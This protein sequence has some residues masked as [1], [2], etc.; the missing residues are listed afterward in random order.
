MSLSS[1]HDL[2][3]VM[4]QFQ[5][6]G[7]SQLDEVQ[8]ELP[9]F[10]DAHAFSDW[11]VERGYLTT[12]QQNQL[13]LRRGR[14]LVLGPYRLLEPLGEGGMGQVF[15][16]HHQRLNRVVAL[17]LIRR[18]LLSHQ[19]DAVR[20]FQRE[21]RAVA[22]L[23]HPNVVILYDA[24][25]VDGAH[26]LAME[27][28]DGI[29][30]AQMVYQQGPLP[31]A[32]ACDYVRQ[33]ALG[34]QHAY[35]KGM[36]HRDIKPGNLLVTRPSAGGRGGRAS[37]PQR[38]ASAAADDPTASGAIP[39]SPGGVVKIL[40]M[41][42]VRLTEQL[43][44]QSQ[45]SFLTQHGS[46][47]GTPDFIAP[48]QARDASSVDIRAD[49][50]SLGCT[51]Y[52]L[53]TGRQPF[54]TGSPV[55]KLLKHQ[56]E[57]PMPVE[58][59]RP[60]TP[61]E[62]VIILQRMMAKDRDNRYQTPAEVAE[63]LA[64]L[65]A[66]AAFAPSSETATSSGPSTPVSP[67]YPARS[68]GVTQAFSPESLVLAAR[69]VA[70]MQG[71][72]GYV[73]A[74]A[75][76]SD[77]GLLASGGVDSTVRLW[78]VS[79]AQAQE[80]AVLAANTGEVSA[81]AF[82]PSG[83]FLVT[84]AGSIDG[85]LWRWDLS[86]SGGW[87]R[88]KF[89]GDSYRTDALAFSADG[90]LLAAASGKAVRLW[91]ISGKDVK[92]P[93][94]LQG[95]AGIVRDVAFAPDNRRFA[96][97]GEDGTVRIWEVGRFW[98]SQKTMFTGHTD[99]VTSVVFSPDGR[100]LASA[101]L[102]RSIRLWDGSGATDRPLDVFTG[103]TNPIRLARFTPNGRLLITVADGGQV[104]LWDVL[105]RAKVREW[106]LDQPLLYSVAISPSGRHLAVGTGVGRVVLLDL[107]I[108]IAALPGTSLVR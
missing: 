28:V 88:R 19:P 32:Q 2:F 102:D 42:L 54:P 31:I 97:G 27:Y 34:L 41:G 37:G 24:D 21:A 84:G 91:G 98:T 82:A 72:K 10:A 61:S 81:V 39:R 62:V 33:A 6:L 58:K 45:V 83:S 8:R 48:E 22:Q 78:D 73:M 92:R 79:S 96:S 90:T 20:R 75:F 52:F 87:E 94:V 3:E 13:L 26:F 101:S 35:E 100:L 60:Q 53:L 76:S 25:E 49:I 93:S 99:G 14:E 89:P 66:P 80:L 105:G 40:D 23:L 64:G 74:L 15:K 11:L 95:H 63:A 44:D 30:L 18:E 17:K 59:I 56:T 106:Q 43:G 68:V 104:F 65:H 85:N 103:H 71:H 5:L 29:D 12:Y 46:V 51:F 69:K 4:R 36:V 7:S 70:E 55:E 16:A 38:R 1:P 50:Y 107:E 47:I 108:L 67:A 57:T 9:R 86:E 77:G